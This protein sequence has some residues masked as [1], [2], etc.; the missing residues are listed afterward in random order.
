MKKLCWI[1][2]SRD[3]VEDLEKFINSFVNN[4]DASDLFI[5]LDEDDSKSVK[6]YNENKIKEY[7]RERVFFIINK[8]NFHG[9]FLHILNHY[10]KIMTEKY[11]YIGFLEDDCVIM[12]KHFDSIISQYNENVIYLNDKETQPDC[13]AGAP[14]IKSSIIESLGFYSPP[15]LKCLWADKYWK[16]LGDLTESIKFLQNV[17]I[18]H[19]HYSFSNNSKVQDE[20]GK[21]IENIGHEDYRTWL[22][23]K[24]S[25]HNNILN[26]L[27]MKKGI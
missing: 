13:Y 23:Y 9:A 14:I 18:K 25:F 26:K 10:S 5:I 6:F 7:S 2:P 27:V 21:R 8:I 24:K 19:E 17:I 22:K 15:E 11:E 4:N 16:D 20:I 12:T 1:V 3:R